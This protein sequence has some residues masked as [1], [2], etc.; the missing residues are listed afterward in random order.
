MGRTIPSWRIIIEETF[1]RW[2]RFQETLRSDERGIFEDLMNDCRRYA[3]AAGAS[4]F[5]VKAE[6]IF[7]AIIFAHHKKLKELEDKID[8]LI[9]VTEED[10]GYG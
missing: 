6:G 2:R 7:L 3:S 8:R 4:V 1:K 10:D 9:S 5:P